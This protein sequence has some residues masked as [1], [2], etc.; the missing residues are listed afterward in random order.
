MTDPL[1]DPSARAA[2]RRDETRA[3]AAPAPDG[4]AAPGPS[5]PGASVPG[6]S[7]PAD[8][9]SAA[10][11]PA[12]G[13]PAVSVPASL[14]A[15]PIAIGMRALAGSN[16]FEIRLDPYELGRI[17]VSLDIDRQHG[18]VKAHL[19]VDR[20]ETLA[21][22]QRD[23]G[24]LQQ[25]LAQAG[26]HPGEAGL[27]FSLRDGD[28]GRGAQRDQAGRPQG[29]AGPAEPEAEITASAP[30]RNLGQRLGLDLRI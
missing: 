5:T 26:L 18:A 24:S 9:A 17:D 15:V 13:R 7:A 19:V 8:A 30:L 16:R 6:A 21:L 12:E 4:L 23:A 27:T 3:G 20:P 1:V 14:S 2:G 22:L 10:P 28:G 11:A 29:A 25:A